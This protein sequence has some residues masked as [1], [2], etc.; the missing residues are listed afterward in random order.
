MDAVQYTGHT[1]FKLFVPEIF[2]PLKD[3][4][5]ISYCRVNFKLLIGANIRQICSRRSAVGTLTRLWVVRP[6]VRIPA[7]ASA[8]L[9]LEGSARLCGLSDILLNRS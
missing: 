6:N 7:E 4:V 8:F 5:K 2:R 3:A 9:S 1:A